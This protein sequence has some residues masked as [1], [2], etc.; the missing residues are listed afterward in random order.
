MRRF[1]SANGDLGAS[2]GEEEEEEGADEF[3]KECDD[4]I[5]NGAAWFAEA[6]EE[7]IGCGKGGGLHAF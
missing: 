4:V 1:V 3:A 6:A 5:S 7:G 2:E